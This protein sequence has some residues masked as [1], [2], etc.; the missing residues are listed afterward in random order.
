MNNK[1]FLFLLGVSSDLR[2]RI[3]GTLSSDLRGR[4]SGT[5]LLSLISAHMFCISSNFPSEG[6]Q[7]R[8]TT[9]KAALC[10][11]NCLRDKKCKDDKLS[12]VIF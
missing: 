12:K 1:R 5:S 4:I 2:G 9:A 10:S 8:I 7:Q 3:S 6:G 11:L